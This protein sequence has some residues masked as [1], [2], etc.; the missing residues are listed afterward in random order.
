MSEKM[1]SQENQSEA[2]IEIES[3]YKGME[4]EGFSD[5]P[6]GY[7]DSEGTNIK[8]GEVK[9]DDAGRI[10]E[11][12]SATRDLP[13]WYDDAGNPF[14]VVGKK[15]NLEKSQI[16]KTENPFHEYEVMQIAKEFGLPAAEVIARVSRDNEYLMV[17]K[18][19]EGLRWNGEGLQELIAGGLT[20]EEIQDLL[21]EAE[22]MMTSLAEVYESIG[23]SRTWN[24]KDMIFHIDIHNKKLLGITPTD[25]ERT[26]IDRAT[27]E[28]ARSQLA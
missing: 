18:R 9:Y 28:Q 27:L 1:S 5:D 12:P 15:I 22:E 16:A 13:V 19:V 8:S 6:F 25:W 14:G 4:P 11:D 24:H 3:E 23:V 21:G 20:E 2:K 26:K 17:M 10:I 7:F